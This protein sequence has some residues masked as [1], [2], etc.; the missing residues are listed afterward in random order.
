MQSVQK[1]KPILSKFDAETQTEGKLIRNQ[2]KKDGLFEPS[3]FIR[4]L[5]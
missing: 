5:C 2:H 3:F 1:E 4:A